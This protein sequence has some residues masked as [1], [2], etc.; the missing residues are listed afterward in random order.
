MA[1]L[2]HFCDANHNDEDLI[3]IDFMADFVTWS[4]RWFFTAKYF[5]S[6]VLH[7]IKLMHIQI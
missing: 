4:R 1:C 2:V 7:K 6:E 5:V 3:S